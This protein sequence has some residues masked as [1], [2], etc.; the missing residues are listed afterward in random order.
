[1]KNS[2][3]TALICGLIAIFA[4]LIIF[5]FTFNNIFTVPM[6]WMSLTFLLISECILTLKVVFAKKTVIAQACNFTSVA[7]FLA[8]LVLSVV[9]V[10]LFPFSFKTYI[11]LNIL[12]L[13][14]L[15]AIDVIILNFDKGVSAENKK[16]AQSQGV[17]DA[18]YA[19]A[20]GLIAVYGET[21]HKDALISI[22]ELIKYSDN[23][24]LTGD[25]PDIMNRLTKLE[26]KLNEGDE[27]VPLIIKEI[28]NAIDLRSIKMKSNKRGGY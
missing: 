9:F 23:S 22:A 14:A 10:N 1:M 26:G 25:E 6:R 21:E 28:K 11:L 17:M 2:K 7:L 13:F 8:T 19:K 3:L 20:K 16:L 12:I 18:C 24:E 4:T 5:L 15:T 27:N